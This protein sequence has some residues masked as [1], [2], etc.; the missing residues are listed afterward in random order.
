MENSRVSVALLLPTATSPGKL[1]PEIVQSTNAAIW[2][3]HNNNTK[4]IQTLKHECTVSVLN[5]RSQLYNTSSVQR[6]PSSSTG[7]VEYT[8][9]LYIISIVYN[10]TGLFA[11]STW[12]QKCI[13]RSFSAILTLNIRALPQFSKPDSPKVMK[14]QHWS[15]SRKQIFYQAFDSW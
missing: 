8:N 3:T 11:N 2:M 15:H 12:S 10:I 6:H 13:A 9:K 4:W 7:F 14:I 5:G 1:A